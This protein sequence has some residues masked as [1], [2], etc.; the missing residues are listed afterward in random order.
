M[1]VAAELVG[2]SA[3]GRLLAVCGDPFNPPHALKVAELLP[4]APQTWT[5]T[6]DPDAPAFRVVL[7][8]RDREPTHRAEGPIWLYRRQPVP[9][10]AW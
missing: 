1:S 6:L 2:G 4:T 3:D 10:P 8:L 9:P 5:K 7:Y